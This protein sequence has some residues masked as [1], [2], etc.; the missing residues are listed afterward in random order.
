M[1]PCFV[2]PLFHGAPDGLSCRGPSGNTIAIT[3]TLSNINATVTRYL[4]MLELAEVFMDAQGLGWSN[5]ITEGSQGEG[6]SCLLG[7]S[8]SR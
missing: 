7:L 8:S 3:I 6:L 5:S 1:F 4:M 2:P